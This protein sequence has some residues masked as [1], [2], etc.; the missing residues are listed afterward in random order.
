M[1]KTR[2]TSRVAVVFMVGLVLSGCSIKLAYNN[3]D[4]LIRWG[5]SDYV[6]LNADQKERLNV[7]IKRIHYWH[8]VNHLPLYAEFTKGLAVTLTDSVSVDEVQALFDHITGWV[9]EME[10][11]ITPVVI[12]MMISLTD[13]QIAALPAKLEKS[14]VEIAEP[15]LDAELADAQALWAKEVRQS[16]RPF[17]GRLNREQKAYIER[18]AL[19]Y[20]PE[21]VLWAEYRRR[22]QN[23]LLSLLETRSD[24]TKFEL[25]Y[26]QL[27]AKRETF[28]GP[29][30]DQIY[31]LN[32][33]LNLETGIRVLSM[34]TERQSAKFAEELVEL[35]EDFAELAAEADDLASPS[36]T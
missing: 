13:E 7:E 33:R 25:G 17:V 36:S 3:V 28:Y 26:R 19:G 2:F 30:L 10:S 18:R 22:F 32:Q 6:D 27:I 31:K 9:D 11:E 1:S 23:A 12:D 4:R 24:R 21:R 29:E 20:E 8:R 15:E 14:N 5:I 35:S 34:L 16:L